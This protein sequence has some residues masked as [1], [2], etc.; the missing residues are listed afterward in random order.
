MPESVGPLC[1]GEGGEQESERDSWPAGA[2][3]EV[4][5]GSAGWNTY[6]QNSART[7][8]AFCSRVVDE[9]CRTR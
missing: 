6:G 5:T 8:E 3:G 7:V 9:R 4:E 2:G 1:G